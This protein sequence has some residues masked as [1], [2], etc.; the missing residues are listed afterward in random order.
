MAEHN[1]PIPPHYNSAKV[2]EVWNVSYEECAREAE[3]WARGK[4]I[5]PSSQDEF[6]LSL[7]LVDLQNTFCIPGFELYVGGASGTAAI[8]DNCRLC[9]FIYRNLDGITEICPTM[10]THLAM[11]IF[12]SIFLVSKKGEH[13]E[14]FTLITEEDI[15]GGKWQLNPRLAPSLGITES[16]GREYLRHY[17]HQLKVGGKLEYTI[18]PYHA[19]LG[20][21]G[22]ALVSAVE[23]AVFFHS[24]AR[25]T[26]PDFQVKGDNPLTE[27]YSVLSPEVTQD[28]RGK[29]IA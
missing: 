7:V 28:S 6:R 9:E 8:E 2:G 20:G 21:I 15:V 25:C 1:L 26:P 5:V 23:E 19:M 27:H 17:V 14:P 18:W 29:T 13:P 10:D 4:N 22:H 12:H 3:Q 24:I 16:Y 11:Q